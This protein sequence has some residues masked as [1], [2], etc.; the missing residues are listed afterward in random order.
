MSPREEHR[1]GFSW[2]PQPLNAEADVLAAHRAVE[3]ARAESRRPAPKARPD[4][5]P[6]T[7]W[8]SVERTFFGVTRGT[9]EQRAR[10]TLWQPDATDAYC[11][12]CGQT[13][14][15]FEALA[16]PGESPAGAC[17][18]CAPST[19]PWNR[20]VRMGAYE[21]VL[22]D[23]ILEVK[24]SAW[25]RLGSDLGREHGLVVL[26]ALREAGVD[27]RDALLIPVP[28]S[29]WRRI[30][31]GIDHTL[32]IARAMSRSSGI[33]LA[34]ILHREHRPTQTGRTLDQR[35]R[36]VAKTMHAS[37]GTLLHN[38][39][40]V[41]ALS[42]KTILLVDDVMT[43]GA[44]MREGCRAIAE[45]ARSLPASSDLADQPYHLWACPLAVTNAVD[46][47]GRAGHLKA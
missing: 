32:T 42:G 10:D 23:C 43:S 12:R 1:Q 35:R 29:A 3:I 28:T 27:P 38:G 9:W 4:P 33:T 19:V 41:G 17:S 16:V 14:G 7:W 6:L 8:A 25:R 26:E 18:H 34:P 36:N 31:R 45:W 21:G 13:V 22:R 24:F 40:P 5:Q 15:L 2:P 44:T 20:V 39:S 46:D 30:K 47:E 37:T 11:A